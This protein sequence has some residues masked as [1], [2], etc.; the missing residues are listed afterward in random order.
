MQG[1]CRSLKNGGNSHRLC[2]PIM[3][4]IGGVPES[5]LNQPIHAN[6]GST[7]HRDSNTANRRPYLIPY[8]KSY[9]H[10]A[11]IVKQ[12][13][14]SILPELRPPP[15]RSGSPSYRRLLGVSTRQWTWPHYLATTTVCRWA[16]RATQADLVPELSTFH[17]ILHA[18]V[19]ISGDVANTTLTVDHITDLEPLT[20]TF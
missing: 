11:G 5:I 10:Q 2:E 6:M 1:D 9:G 8:R 19:S 16:S 18:H 20:W 17:H 7:N 12:S 15:P 3:Q 4:R 14:L 13:S